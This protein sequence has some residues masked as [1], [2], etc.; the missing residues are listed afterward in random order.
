MAYK[1]KYTVLA[2]GKRATTKR[3]FRKKATAQKALK[4]YYDFNKARIVKI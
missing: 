2:T 1:I 4:K 3:T